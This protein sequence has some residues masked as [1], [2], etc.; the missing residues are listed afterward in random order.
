M[1]NNFW[2][3]F[4]N[5]NNE[6]INANLDKK[7]DFIIKRI[8]NEAILKTLNKIDSQNTSNIDMAYNPIDKKYYIKKDWEINPNWLTA[9]EFIKRFWD[10][11]ML[12]DL[13]EQENAES[14]TTRIL[15][16]QIADLYELLNRNPDNINAA[17]K[18]SILERKYYEKTWF[19]VPFDKNMNMYAPKD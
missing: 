9:N 2:K 1:E 19:P 6:N 3:D 12:I 15:T 4:E 17:K 14:Y 8:E 16:D 11:N 5:I 13:M 10:T 7:E 18:V